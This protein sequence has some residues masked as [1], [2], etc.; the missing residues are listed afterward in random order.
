MITDGTGVIPKA[1][2]EGLCL[3][4]SAATGD[5][6]AIVIS[7]TG[8]VRQYTIHDGDDDGLLEGTL[9][10]EFEVGSESE[11]CVADDDNGDLYISEENVGLWRYGAEPTAGAARTTVDSVQPSGHLA[12]DVE[13]VTLVDEPD[14]SGYVLVSSQNAV[15]PSQNYYVVY[16]GLTNAY[17]KSFRI[18]DGTADGCSRTDGIAATAA[19]L[20]PSFP[21]GVFIC[22]D[23]D[24]FAPGSAGNRTSS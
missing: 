14:G 16:D 23:N 24:N 2:G 3:Y 13:G 22:Q 8:R 19:S 20:G 11:G 15:S 5:V 18:V 9:V 1:F 17:V 7:I 21:Q 6:S 4:D 10:R 12:A